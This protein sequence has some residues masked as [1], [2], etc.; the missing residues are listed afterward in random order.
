MLTVLMLISSAPLAGFVGFEWPEFKAEAASVSGGYLTSGY[1]GDPAEGDT[2]NIYWE[3]SDEGVLTVT[4]TGKI[5]PE[6]FNY[7]LRIKEVIISDGITNISDYCFNQCSN[8]VKVTMGEG[9]ETIG[10]YAFY[11]CSKLTEII[12]P[13]TLKTIKNSAISD[14]DALTNII[15][16]DSL[17]RLE[18]T[19]FG[20]SNNISCINIPKAITKINNSMF[21][22]CGFTE[23]TFPETVQS[24]D[25]ANWSKLKTF[26]I[27]NRYCEY[28]STDAPTFAK[29][30]TIRAYCGSL[31]HTFATKRLL[32]F[33]SIGHT[34]LDWY[35]YQPAT[36]EQDG[37][38][39]RDCAYCDGYDERIT[40]KLENDVFTATFVADGEVVATVDFPKGTTSITEPK[41]PAK[42]RYMGEWEEYTLAD[43]DITINAIYTLIKSEDASEIETESDAIHYT[44]KDDVLFKF[45]AWAD[46]LVVKSTVS[47]SVPLDIVL[48]VDQSGSM[49]ETLG[50]R[51]K[52]V[53]ALKATAK[54]F[55]NTVLENAKITGA[56]HRISLVGF[57]L[58]GNYQGFEKNENTELLT[59]GRG[60]VKFDDIKTTD[61]ASSLLS[62]NV[63][64]EVND[65]LIDA[66]D[67][68]DARGAT[69]ADLGFEMAKG[70][71]AN[72]DST[73]R[74]RVVVFM[75]D[76]EP[77]YSSSFQTSVANSAIYNAS[78]LKSA[79]DASIYSVG[80]F[81]AIDSN[82]RN[83]KKFMNAVSSGYPDALSMSYL[84]KGVDGQYYL[85]VNNTDSLSDVFKTI[86]T[87]SLS[88]T[89][90][91]DN[92]TF[93]KKSEAKRS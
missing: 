5:V 13:N 86:S 17:E 93:I 89:A 41:V 16:P 50:G 47:K 24:F 23:L 90:P 54:D 26:T 37:I 76:G 30:C 36:F 68:I 70:V 31:G 14:C 61:Y 6:S 65:K 28:T 1:C 52:K 35:T 42:D 59:S 55:V 44:D 33:E 32:N 29:D 67:A 72:T 88:H 92:L 66:I 73:D 60:I 18:S 77:T 62:V 21:A 38:E 71:F 9:V 63:D 83:I 11:Q 15:L 91:F 78:L 74:Q 82:N 7:D 43:A 58:S 22:S 27:L 20:Y 46:A 84:G 85:T 8:L 81:S 10:S 4:G 19:A 45:R 25:H 3:L 69:A 39:R 75:T 2:K 34:Y 48:V 80:I 53:D 57:G 51:T 49:D 64:G 12:F 79:Y 56:D 40:P 87:E